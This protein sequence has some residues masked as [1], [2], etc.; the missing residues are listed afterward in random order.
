M[1]C[2]DLLGATVENAGK[3]RALLRISDCLG[4]FGR[5]RRGLAPDVTVYVVLVTAKGRC[6]QFTGIVVALHRQLVEPVIAGFG[7][8]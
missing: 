6:A 1:K 7:N 4:F 2:S 8:R 3:R 5:L